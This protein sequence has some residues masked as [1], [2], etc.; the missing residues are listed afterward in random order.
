MWLTEQVERPP[1]VLD[2]NV[3][4]PVDINHELGGGRT[5]QWAKYAGHRRPGRPGNP[6]RC[7]RNKVPH[8]H[9]TARGDEGPPSPRTC[10]VV[11]LGKAL[12]ARMVLF[13]AQVWR[14]RATRLPTLHTGGRGFCAGTRCAGWYFISQ[15]PVC[16]FS[17]RSCCFS[18][19]T[20]RGDQA[21]P[22]R[23]FQWATSFVR[24]DLFKPWSKCLR[25][26][27]ANAGGGGRRCKQS[28]V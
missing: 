18:N 10:N 20:T 15:T 17:C 26:L 24:M 19:G 8:G 22:T 28:I 4:M 7:L 27:C 3:R 12:A 11:A 6:S 13:Y 2:N 5:S 25:R 23:T 9:W 1:R 21:A 16:P 14:R